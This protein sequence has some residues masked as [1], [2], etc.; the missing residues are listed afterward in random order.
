MNFSEFFIKKPVFCLVATLLLVLIGYLSLIDLPLRQYPNIEKSQITIDT[1]YP[2]SASSIV[3]TKITEIIENQISGIEGI[4]SIDSVSRDGRSKVNIEFNQDKNIDEAANDVRDAISRVI[5]R[6]PKDSDT[7][8]I[9]KIDSDAEAVMWLNLTSN[10]LNQMELTEYAE[11][12]LVDRLSVVP[13]VAKIRISVAKKKSLRIWINPLHPSLLS[14][15]IPN[16]SIKCFGFYH[17]KYFSH[18]HK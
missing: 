3:E 9:Y 15:G 5:G 12:F 14:K 18:I 7:P 1:R 17:T 16:L 11:K 10:N 4:R 2:G 6:L 8:E 13:G